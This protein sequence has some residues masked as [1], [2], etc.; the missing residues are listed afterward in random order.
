MNDIKDAAPAGLPD[1]AYSRR[2]IR[3][4]LVKPR[5]QLR[6]A[7][8]FF[9]GGLAVM[10]TYIIMFLYY[11]NVTIGNLAT[12]YSIAPD[13]QSTIST[14]LL[15]ASIAT[16]VFAATLTLIMF[17]AGVALSHRI[18]GPAIPILRLVQDLRDGN[19]KARGHLRKR[20]EF[21]DI[22]GGLNELAGDL[23]KK[24]GSKK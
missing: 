14:A 6:Y 16:I 3:S 8:I 18:F 5:E 21:Q 24:Y 4:I 7:F 13:V 20:D 1:D 19:Y 10:A 17:S 23:E 11:L 9:G 15:T 22:M 2:S 12:S